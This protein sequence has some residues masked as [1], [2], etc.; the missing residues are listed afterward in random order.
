MGYSAIGLFIL[1]T[2]RVS[3]NGSHCLQSTARV[4]F[5]VRC[6]HTYGIRPAIEG[7]H[8]RCAPNVHP[9]GDQCSAK[10]QVNFFSLFAVPF[11]VIVVPVVEFKPR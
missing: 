8:Y 4:A 9:Y 10:W 3:Q 7:I 6:K 1:Q 11:A 5:K 2:K